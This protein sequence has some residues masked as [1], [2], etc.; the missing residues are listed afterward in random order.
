M[1]RIGQP[2]ERRRL[3]VFVTALT[4]YNGQLIAGGGLLIAG[5]TV[6]NYYCCM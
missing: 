6:A 3:A 1:V 2:L 5:G 4:V